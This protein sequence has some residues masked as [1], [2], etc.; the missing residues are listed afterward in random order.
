MKEDRSWMARYANN[1]QAR[2]GAVK[3]R[4][5]MDG[6][7]EAAE[8]RAGPWTRLRRGFGDQRSVYH[9][10]LQVIFARTKLWTVL[11]QWKQDGISLRPCELALEEMCVV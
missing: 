7:L 5:R 4:A 10:G 3:V 9:D 6:A 8:D 1:A 11:A 2:V